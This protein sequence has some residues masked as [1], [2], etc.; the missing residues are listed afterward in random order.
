MEALLNTWKSLSIKKRMILFAS[1]VGTMA[2]MALIANMANKPSMALL[3]AGLDQGAAGE[4]VAALDQKNV[5]YE[6]R[7]ES[8]YIASDARDRV[9]MELAK[10]GLPAQGQGGYE[11]LDSLSGFSTTA[12]MF[13]AAYWRAKEGELARTILAGPGVRS[14]RV[15]IAASN[16][17]PFSRTVQTSSASVTIRMNGSSALTKQQAMSMRYLVALAV[18]D[19]KPEQVAVIDAVNGVI[20]RPGEDQN[21]EIF[22]TA[23]QRESALSRQITDL[24]AVRVGADRVQ[25]SVNID[26]STDVEKTTERVLDPES[27]VAISSSTKNRESTSTGSSSAVTVASN[28][29]DGEAAGGN[30]NKSSLEEADE[31]INYEYSETMREKTSFAGAVERVSVAVLVDQVSTVAEDGT[32]TYTPRSV[33][34]LAAIENLVKSASGFD[35]ARGDTVTVESMQFIEIPEAGTLAESSPLMQTLSA[36]IMTIIKS[37]GL[38]GVAVGLMMFVI[39]PMMGAALAARRAELETYS[40]Q[41]R[42]KLE[43]QEREQLRIAQDEEERGNPVNRLRKVV[44][45][46][47]EETTALLTS[48]LEDDD[49]KNAFEDVRT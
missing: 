6:I 9:R 40:E 32:T 24:L 27:R 12:E 11:L 18:A 33:E 39:K 46:K 45:D 16:N 34:E 21:A 41:E 44:S 43:H 5:V 26:M 2:L 29:P 3:Y 37:I 13:D 22:E 47:G 1:V 8:I 20:L 31:N 10:D 25:V 17:R 42:L 19:M 4:V 49:N 28:L 36:N 38:V 7:G 23:A 48:W 35:E 15:H 30:E 14:A